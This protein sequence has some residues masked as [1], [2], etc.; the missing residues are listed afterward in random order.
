MDTD[1]LLWLLPS[2]WLLSA[3]QWWRSR[4]KEKA[5]NLSEATDALLHMSTSLKGEC[6]KLSNE[7][8]KLYGAVRCLTRA[9]TLSSA[10]RY[11]ADC[12]ILAE[13]PNI[14]ESCDLLNDFNVPRT[15]GTSGPR[16]PYVDDD[17][18]MH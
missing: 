3:F 10:C 8:L 2:G 5:V 6:L 7:N 9:I 13:L 14:K 17:P 1:I 4:H 11:S 18:D 12:P 16:Q 15:N